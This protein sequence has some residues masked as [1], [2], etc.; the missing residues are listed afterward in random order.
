MLKTTILHNATGVLDELSG[1]KRSAVKSSH[2]YA[3]YNR[4]FEDTFKP[5]FIQGQSSV[6]SCYCKTY[7]TL[8]GFA[9]LK[10]NEEVKISNLSPLV[11]GV[12]ITQTLLDACDFIFCKDYDIYVPEGAVD[13][14][15]KLKAL[16]FHYVDT[17]LSKD[18]TNQLKFTK[19][20]N[21][22]WI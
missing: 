5:A 19:P 21:I 7:Q 18:L 15:A 12:G 1:V 22:S 13:L 2:Y 17:N 4:W 10:H 8:I 3:G 9:L 14:A 16:G 11:D 6:V 20:R